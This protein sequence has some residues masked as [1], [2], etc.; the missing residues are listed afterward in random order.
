MRGTFLSLADA[1]SLGDGANLEGRALTIAGAVTTNS[2]DVSVCI[3]PDRPVVTL[4][5]PNCS[6]NT[7]SITITSPA[8]TGM[9]YRID[10]CAFTNTTGRIYRRICR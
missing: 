1:I 2:S 8:A 3:K 6:Q 4:T 10:Y 5:Q 9:T 7:G